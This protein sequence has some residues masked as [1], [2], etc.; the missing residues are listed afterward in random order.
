MVLATTTWWKFWGW[1][2]H[3]YMNPTG[4]ILAVGWQELQL[5]ETGYD[6][7]SLISSCHS[8]NQTVVLANN[9]VTV[10]A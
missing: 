3:R 8:K 7:M 2:G 9:L 10:V 6:T 1:I 4:L 5:N